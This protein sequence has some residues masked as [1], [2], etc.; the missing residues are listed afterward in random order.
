MLKLVLSKK[1][2]FRGHAIASPEI[3]E[4]PRWSVHPAVELPDDC[5]IIGGLPLS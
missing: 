2:K 1:R 4:T 5:A 3:R